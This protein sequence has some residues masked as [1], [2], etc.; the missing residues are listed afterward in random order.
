MRLKTAILAFVA[1]ISIAVAQ[2]QIQYWD[3]WVTQ[4]PAIDEVIAT[5]EAQ[6]P[7]IKVVKNTIGGGPYNESID[8]AMQSDSG[9]DVFVIP[10]RDG[11]FLDYVNLNYAYNLSTFDDADAFRTNFPDPAANFLEGSNLIGGQLYSAPFFGP[12]KPWLQLYINTNLYEQAGLVDEEGKAKL[13]VTWVDFIENSRIIKEETG[14]AGLGFSMQQTWAADWLYR[15]CNYSGVPFDG[16]AGGMD[17]RTGEYTFVSNDC[18][19]EVLGDLVMMRDEGLIDGGTL[20]FTYDDEGARALFAEDGFAHLFAGEWVIA[21]WEQTHP[22]FSGYT[23]T[24]VPFPNDEP[25]SFFGAG[26]GGTWFMINAETDHPEASWEFFKFLHSPEAGAIWAR[27]GNGLVLNTPEPFD[28]YAT[29]D[30]F[31]YI[32]ASSDLAKP[33]P[34]P[35]IRNPDLAQVQI[36]LIGPSPGD[37]IVGVVS[38]QITDID[39][40]L[41]D[42]NERKTAALLTGI[43]DAQAAG[44]D[45]SLEDYIFPDWNP[46]EAYITVPGGN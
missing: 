42:L 27:N 41:A 36:T 37:I 8:L 33:M 10:N 14:K 39:A 26:L 5:F 29:N 30:A 44:I 23:A 19:R 7:G 38:G 12:P 43:A 18:Y 35:V 13:P 28:E 22:D 45:I 31:A 25:Q 11:G 32:F 3:F 6:N 15:V 16:F 4:G 2:V 40:S 21:G 20:S 46:T 34:E 17:Y 1:S 24:H 9:P